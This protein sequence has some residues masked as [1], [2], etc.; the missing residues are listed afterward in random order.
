M[1]KLFLFVACLGL[2][3]IASSDLSRRAEASASCT[4]TCSGGTVLRCC[5][6][7]MCTA[8]DG[9]SIDCNGTSMTCGPSAAWADCRD[10]CDS[11]F[12]VCVSHCS[13]NFHACVL[14]CSSARSACYNRCGPAPVTNIGC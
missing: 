2:L 13:V 14:N 10:S 5:T 12:D 1:R 3:A 8:V 9:S 7:G 4:V 6:A 11:A